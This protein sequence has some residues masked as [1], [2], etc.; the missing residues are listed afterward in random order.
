M[1]NGLKEHIEIERLEEQRNSQRRQH[2][3]GVI[4]QQM[5]P[6]DHQELGVAVG[7]PRV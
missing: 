6:V 7:E 5:M 3:V 1:R 2:R 4:G